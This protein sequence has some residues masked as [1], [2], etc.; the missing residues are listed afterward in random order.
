MAAGG[1][2][3]SLGAVTNPVSCGLRDGGCWQGYAKGAIYWSPATGARIV[4]SSPIRDKWATT[5]WERG[6]LGYPTSDVAHTP[7]GG[8]YGHFQNGSIYSSTA[9]GAHTL[10]GAVRDR[11]ASAGYERG[12]GY[13]TQDQAPTPD[14]KAQYEHFQRGSIYWSAATGARIL[15]GAVRD[16]WAAL[17]WERSP[18]GLPVADVGTTP[19]GQAQFAHF[20]HGSI[21]VV[22]GTPRVLPSE[23]VD[24]WRRS[25]W[26]HGPLGYP[27]S[28]VTAAPGGAGQVMTF[29]TGAVYV[30]ED[31]I[32]RALHGAVRTAY[33][34]A[35][36]PAGDLGL[37]TSDVTAS[38]D[39]RA[40]WAMFS[41]GALCVVDG[42]PR[43][44]PQPMALAWQKRG[45]A[46]GS[47]GY[48]SG[49]AVPTTGGQTQAFEGGTVYALG[50]A[51]PLVLSGHVQDGLVAAGGVTGALGFP[52]TEVQTTPDGKAEFAHFQNGSVYWT[53]STG[54]RAVYG[55][56]RTVWGAT[57]WERGLGYPTTSVTATPDGKGQFAHF[58]RGSIYWTPDTG[59]HAVSGPVRDQWAATGWEHGLG[60][61]ITNVS[62]TPD[63]KGQYA[64]FEKGSIYWTAATGAR[65]V[66]GPIKDRWAA[67]GWERGLG[68]PTTSV[69]STPDRVGQFEH[70]QNGSIYWSPT[71]GARVIRGAFYTAWAGSGYERGKLGYPIGEAYAVSG[72]SWQK[73]QH[74]YI[75]YANATGKATVHV[76]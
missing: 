45:G 74:G 14:G 71:T 75:A 18:L 2:Q 39:G 34:T 26:E 29:Q 1:D 10:S 49:D 25:G 48:P 58:Q 64:H 51:T 8:W 22:S 63:G 6:W 73:F 42:T 13:P 27:A 41:H 46:T 65:S 12:L 36:G 44:L 52:V 20:Q 43:V 7:D 53:A 47:L 70:F 33:D 76:T 19:D 4:Y 69:I 30:G 3:G 61:P 57:G 56:V 35:G 38:T 55:P 17:G 62:S 50:T 59:A 68:Y 24:A 5:V 72:G 23:V 15:S 11:W 40:E 60:Y 31:G 67:T 21:Y 66:F 9:T 54:A 32:G 28:D 37:P 16:Q